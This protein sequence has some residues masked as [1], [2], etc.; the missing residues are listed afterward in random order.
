MGVQR[1]Y[2]SKNFKI[3]LPTSNGSHYMNPKVDELLEAAA[4]EPDHAKRKELFSEFQKIV[5]RELP[6][7]NLYTPIYLT[8]HNQRVHDHSVTADGPEG[9]FAQAWV[10]A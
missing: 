9:N 10:D 7:L 5:M 2:W 1:I 3:G 8:I 4:V 6:D